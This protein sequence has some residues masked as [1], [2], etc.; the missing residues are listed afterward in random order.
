MATAAM[1]WRLKWSAMKRACWMLTQNP[2]ARI[3]EIVGVLVD[4]LDDEPGPGVRAGVGGA[5]R[6]DVVAAAAPPRDIA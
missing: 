1:P 4:L 5:E 2:S 6:I 3:V